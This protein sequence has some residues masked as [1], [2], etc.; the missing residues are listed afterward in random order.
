MSVIQLNGVDLKLSL[1]LYTCLLYKEEFKSDLL[2]DMEKVENDTML[3]AQI[4][5]AMIKTNNENMFDNFKDFA[6]NIDN[7]GVIFNE[8]IMNTV[9]AVIA[10][11]AEVTSK[12]KKKGK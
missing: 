2:I 1:S 4:L 5:Y 6:K 12:T 7:I 11:S 8:E 3:M 9:G 10:K